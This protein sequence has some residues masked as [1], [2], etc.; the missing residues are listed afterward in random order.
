[1]AVVF[2]KKFFHYFLARPLPNHVGHEASAVGMRFF[3]GIVNTMYLNKVRAKLAGI[4]THYEENETGDRSASMMSLFKS[5]GKWLE[6]PAVLDANIHISSLAPI[7][8]PKRLGDIIA[9]GESEFRNVWREYLLPY[10]VE[11]GTEGCV[12]EWDRMHFRGDLV[13]DNGRRTTPELAEG[14]SINYVTQI[15]H[16]DPLPL[17]TIPF[18]QPLRGHCT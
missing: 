13:S 12:A 9:G 17:V 8:M 14:P 15:F 16:F 3:E 2:A 6:D 18:T 7:Y 1:M 11:A 5:L 4:S 10:E